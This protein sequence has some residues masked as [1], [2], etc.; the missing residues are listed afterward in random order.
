M[1]KMMT[2]CFVS[3]IQWDSYVGKILDIRKT[4]QVQESSI[5]GLCVRQDGFENG[6]QLYELP[7]VVKW[8]DL[9]VQYLSE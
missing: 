4:N 1:W 3:I 5:S 2:I 9:S 6:M 7:K 8:L